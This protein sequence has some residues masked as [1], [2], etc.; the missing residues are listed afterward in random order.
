[1]ALVL[2]AGTRGHAQARTD[3]LTVSDSAARLAAVRVGASRIAGSPALAPYALTVRTAAS[4]PQGTPALALDDVLRAIPGIQVDN[5]FNFALGE[6]ISIRGTGARAQFGVRGVRV[7]IDGIPATLPDGQTTL[8][9]VDP[10]T[11]VRAE[12]VRGPV[13]SLYGNAGG[14]AI[15]LETAAPPR[16]DLQGS[17]SVVA[18]SS[19]LL[20]TR[21]GA[22]GTRGATSY[23]AAFSRLGYGGFRT[24]SEATNRYAT[25]RVA[26]LG[27]R[28][29]LRLLVNVVDSDALNPGS[30]SDSLLRVDRRRA[31]MNNVAQRTGETAEQ[32]QVGLQWRRAWAGGTGMEVTS[33]GIGRTIDNPIPGRVVVLDRLAGGARALLRGSS[34]RTAWSAGVEHEQQRDARENYTNV[35]GT[36]GALVLDQDER[37]AGSGAFA[38]VSVAVLPRL[39]VL[40]GLRHDRTLFRVD[41][42]LVSSDNP[43]DSGMRILRAFSPSA[44]LSW[45]LDGGVLLYANGGSAFETPTTTELVN[46]PDGAGGFNAGLQPQRTVSYEIGARRAGRRVSMQLAAY[47]SF[48]RDALIPFEV[49]DAPGRQFFR[50]AGRTATS[51]AELGVSA[52]ATERLRLD[53]AYTFTN[54]RF[55]DYTVGA[56]T[57]AGN[58]VPGVAPHRVDASAT[59]TRR[60]GF[61][62]A[63]LRHQ[64]RM[65]VNDA[66]TA[67]AP[68]FTI[69]DIRLGTRAFRRRGVQAT[70][71]A[72]VQNVAG[73]EYNTSVVV[74]AFGRRFYEPGPA[75]TLHV[76]ATVVTPAR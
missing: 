73:S 13:A 44:G 14:G 48:V 26:W 45:L 58:H 42:N 59:L 64:S 9:Q 68:A 53:A 66:N 69:G 38:Q 55:R 19:G 54:A 46:R 3:T 32:Q 52:M 17:A 34:S 60:W 33:W 50:N 10:A 29:F 37:V 11:I 28:D 31:F 23:S 7:L 2:A 72:G 12:V 43:D 4:I 65:A 62:A 41:D 1:M 25:A 39:S 6:R 61:A 36:R 5:R 40:A 22:G 30:L 75:R 57:Y 27:A 21:A 71:T 24:H 56:S 49:P 47:R 63:D 20:R 51:G 8:N 67:H 70:I 15:L 76:G 35:G 16:I 74:N 18:G